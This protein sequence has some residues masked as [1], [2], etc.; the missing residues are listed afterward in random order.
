MTDSD[1]E[2]EFNLRETVHVDDE[3]DHQT[4]V[5]D[6][7]EENVTNNFSIVE[8]SPDETEPQNDPSTD[9]EGGGDDIIT[10]AKELTS[11]QKTRKVVQGPLFSQ[12]REGN[13]TQYFPSRDRKVQGKTFE[14]TRLYL[15][16]DSDIDDHTMPQPHH[17]RS[18]V[19]KRR[20]VDSQD[21]GTDYRHMPVFNHVAGPN[22]GT[23]PSSH[24]MQRP[25]NYRRPNSARSSNLPIL[26]PDVFNG[27]EDWDSYFSHFQN[28]ADLGRWSDHDK[29]LTLASCLKGPARTFYLGLREPERRSYCVLV[30]KL[31]E[32]FGSSRQQT[33]YLTKFETRRR[34]VGE[35]SASYGDDLRLIA[36]RAY[37]DLGPEAQDKLALHQF[38][39]TI[40]PEL[41]YRCIDRGCR[42]VEEAV[43]IV[44]RYESIIGIEERKKSN[45]RAVSTTN[46][47]S[48]C[49]NQGQISFQ[50][51]IE[52]L[53]KRLKKIE[54]KVT[55]KPKRKAPPTDYT[56]CFNCNSLEHYARDCPT[57]PD[58]YRKWSENSKPLA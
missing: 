2:I 4:L 15:E 50:E 26:K 19:A 6:E 29:A 7:E 30:Q 49:Q 44:E 43:E 45:V 13:P 5:P 23:E 21:V 36:Q 48:K 16:S 9:E 11:M 35:T 32:R 20:S 41:K 46:P 47:D 51:Q 27:E 52:E 39:K 24:Y 10:H 34:L 22:K 12:T 42:T 53:T 8:N 56:G 17:P 1:S 37:P 25:N 55:Y 3:P 40:S 33:R 54:S 14:N 31:N 38:F 28:C 57:K 18:H 58:Q